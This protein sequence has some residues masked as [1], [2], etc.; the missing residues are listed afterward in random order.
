M[1]STLTGRCNIA[2]KASEVRKIWPPPSPWDPS[3]TMGS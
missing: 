2:D 1:R 3:M